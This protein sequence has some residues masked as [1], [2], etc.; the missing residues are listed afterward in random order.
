MLSSLIETSKSQTQSS[1][2]DMLLTCQHSE[3]QEQCKAVQL[4]PMMIQR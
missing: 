2:R 1:M 3:G 4:M